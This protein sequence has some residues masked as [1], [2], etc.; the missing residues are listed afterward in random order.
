MFRESLEHTQAETLDEL[1]T[2]LKEVVILCLKVMDPVGIEIR[3]GR[4]TTVPY[5]SSKDLARPLIRTI[6]SNIN[7]SVQEYSDLLK[8]L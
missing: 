2:R 4:T 7:I 8:N 5:H 1:Y 3:D 6:L